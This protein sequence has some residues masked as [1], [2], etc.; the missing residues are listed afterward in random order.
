MAEPLKEAVLLLPLPVHKS[1]KAGWPQDISGGGWLG[2]PSQNGYFTVRF[3]H[4]T[5]SQ[6]ACVRWMRNSESKMVSNEL[7][8]ITKYLI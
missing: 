8:Y 5:V 3:P 4:A 7:G 2:M 6:S 1:S